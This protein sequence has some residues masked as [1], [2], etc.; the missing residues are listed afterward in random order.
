MKRKLPLRAALLAL[1]GAFALMG[2]AAALADDY[3]A[4]DKP[5]TT[6]QVDKMHWTGQGGGS[7]FKELCGDAADEQALDPN[8][9]LLWIFNFDHG[10]LNSPPTLYI[11]GV[12]QPAG[13]AGN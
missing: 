3:Y 11:N 10:S 7:D 6:N 12:A 13:T 5:T 1:V 2:V 9:Y 8:N 4:Q